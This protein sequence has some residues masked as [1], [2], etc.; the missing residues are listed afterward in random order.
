MSA[1]N[2]WILQRDKQGDRRKPYLPLATDTRSEAFIG[3]FILSVPQ[4]CG[5]KASRAGRGACLYRLGGLCVSAL[6]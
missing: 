5:F 3:L 6:G 2:A 1:K 4:I